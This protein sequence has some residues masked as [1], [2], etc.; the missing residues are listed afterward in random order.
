MTMET[1]ALDDEGNRAALEHP[2]IKL[3]VMQMR[4]NDTRGFWDNRSD[5]SLLSD[6]VLTRE[7][8]R[9]LP[10]IADPDPKVLW[11]LQMFY[12]TVGLAIER[13]AG[14][15]ASP[16]V[17][18]S[19]EGYGRVVLLAGRLVALSRQLRDVHRFGFDSLG[20]LAAEGDKL[21]GEAVGTINRYP[22]VAR[23]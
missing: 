18:L 9:Q 10:I 3:L 7:Q 20:D 4:A 16:L 11:R 17:K 2:F 1:A 15:I 21:V 6:F 19:H 13:E 5:V 12:N 23:L 22:E 14:I 8:R